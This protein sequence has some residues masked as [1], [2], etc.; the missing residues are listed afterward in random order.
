MRNFER[1]LHIGAGNTGQTQANNHRAHRKYVQVVDGD[2]NLPQLTVVIA[3]DKKDVEAF[4]QFILPLVC[5]IGLSKDGSRY[6]K[7]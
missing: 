4:L 2:M 3:S 1:H 7:P 5:R 6:E